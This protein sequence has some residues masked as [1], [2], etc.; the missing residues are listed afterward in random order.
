MGSRVVIRAV[1]SVLEDSSVAQSARDVFRSAVRH[2]PHLV[3]RLLHRAAGDP[4]VQLEDLEFRHEHQ[5]TIYLPY[6]RSGQVVDVALDPRQAGAGV[7]IAGPARGDWAAA[8][9]TLPY[10]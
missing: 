5:G 4:K 10:G 2:P 6:G 7:S 1:R 8:P 3:H 9:S